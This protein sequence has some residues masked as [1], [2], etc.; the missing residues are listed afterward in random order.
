MESTA[1][2]SL[3]IRHSLATLV[4]PNEKDTCIMKWKNIQV[5]IIL[6]RLNSRLKAPVKFFANPV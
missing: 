4:I 3:K 6:L 5:S 2:E 1:R